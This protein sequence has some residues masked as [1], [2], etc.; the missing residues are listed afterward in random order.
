MDFSISSVYITGTSRGLGNTLAIELLSKGAKVIGIGRNSSIV[1]LNYHHVFADLSRI[2]QIKSLN[3]SFEDSSE[4][5]ILINNAAQLGKVVPFQK[6]SEEEVIET[7]HLNFLAP[8]LLIKKFLNLQCNDS[9]GKYVINIGTGAANQ[10]IDGWSLYCSTKA[11]LAMFSKVVHLE[12]SLDRAA[13]KIVDLAPGI[14]DTDMQ[15]EIRNA[16]QS[17]FSNVEKFVN[18]KEA[19]A[20]QSAKL[21][22]DVIIRNFDSLFNNNSP[23]E[24]IRNYT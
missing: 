19:N 4:N 12:D 17:D 1:H 14:L 2:E 7:T 18:Y 8:L 6:L 22:A 15:K 9:V 10:P 23:S 3:I 16:K 24:S 5:L 21:T 13:C 11:G 20:L